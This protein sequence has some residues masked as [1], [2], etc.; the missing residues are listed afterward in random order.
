VRMVPLPSTRTRAVDEALF[1]NLVQRAFAQRRKMLRRALGDW[2]NLIPWDEIGVEPTARAEQVDVA[3][4]IRM[5]D[6]LA[7]RLAPSDSLPTT[8][9]A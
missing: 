8:T 3:G 7:Q 9:N 2:T 6:A 4:F 1:A 5:S